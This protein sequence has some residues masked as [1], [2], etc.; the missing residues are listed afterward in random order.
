MLP[1]QVADFLWFIFPFRHSLNNIKLNTKNYTNRK[2][3]YIPVF[4]IYTHI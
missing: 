3:L 1:W 2:D 4:A